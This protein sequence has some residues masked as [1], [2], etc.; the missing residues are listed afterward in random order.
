MQLIIARRGVNRSLK[1][2]ICN[3][4]G[5]RAGPFIRS[6]RVRALA[7]ANETPACVSA[8]MMNRRA[9][10]QFIKTLVRPPLSRLPRRAEVVPRYIL[11][12]HSR[13]V[14]LGE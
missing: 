9:S 5:L 13:Y 12:R 10:A 11:G 7:R 8:P 3:V 2:L 14:H 1:I 4:T 6:V